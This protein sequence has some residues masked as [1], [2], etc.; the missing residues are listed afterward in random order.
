MCGLFDLVQQSRDLVRCPCPI[1]SLS[2]QHQGP[3]FW[4]SHCFVMITCCGHLRVKW[5][6]QLWT[7]ASR[8]LTK[9]WFSCPL[10]Y[11]QQLA[12]KRGIPML[13]CCVADNPH[14]PMCSHTRSGH[15]RRTPRLCERSFLHHRR[16]HSATDEGDCWHWQPAIRVAFSLSLFLQG[17][18]NFWK[19]WKSGI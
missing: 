13:V 19:Y 18:C 12:V 15:C 9:L 1:A 6:E 10:F 17:V 7:E 8:V 14:V 11:R 4:S 3:M 5:G 16:L 2:N